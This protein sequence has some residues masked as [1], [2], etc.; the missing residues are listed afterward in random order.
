MKFFSITIPTYE[1]KGLGVEYLEHSF[2][3]LNTQTFKDF[4]IV[5]S[6][7]SVDDVIKSLCEKWSGLLDIKYH[8]NEN[9]RGNDETP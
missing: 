8:K 9:K 7:H 5:V 4:E 3:I 1:M 6:D 2:N